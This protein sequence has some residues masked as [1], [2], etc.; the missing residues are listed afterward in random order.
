MD[1]DANDL[2]HCASSRIIFY[3]APACAFWTPVRTEFDRIILLLLA[4]RRK[5]LHSASTAFR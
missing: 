2:W 5:R 4:A 3:L 1:S